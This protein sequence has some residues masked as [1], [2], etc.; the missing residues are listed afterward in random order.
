MNAPYESL[1]DACVNMAGAEAD[2][3]GFVFRLEP[4]D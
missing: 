4:E 1:C 3:D 2:E